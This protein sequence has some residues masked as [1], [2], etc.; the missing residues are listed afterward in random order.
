MSKVLYWYKRSEVKIFENGSRTVYFYGGGVTVYSDADT[1]LI[2]RAISQYG[3]ATQLPVFKMSDVTSDDYQIPGL[4]AP[5]DLS[6]ICTSIL[7]SGDTTYQ[8]EQINIQ[9]LR[10]V[11]DQQYFVVLA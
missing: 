10:D 5:S 3:Y 1:D 4:I 8:S 11:S 6:R 7:N 2:Q 9:H